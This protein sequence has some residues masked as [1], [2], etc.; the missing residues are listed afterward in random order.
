MKIITDS[1][2]TKGDWRI[3]SDQG[4]ELK[5][6]LTPGTNVSAQTLQVV[7]NTI[8]D[9]CSLICREF[10]AEAVTNI[11][12]YTAGVVT[13]TI[14]EGIDKVLR[15]AFPKADIEIQND[16][17]GCARA[18][19]GRRPGVAAILGT[20]SNSCQWDGK[21]IVSHV[22]SGGYILGDEG[23]ASVLGK[24]FLADLI[25]GRVPAEIVQEFADEGHPTGYGD[26]VQAVYH[27]DGA[28][29][30]FLGSLAPFIARHYFHP[31][32]KELVNGNFRDF[33][34]GTLLQYG[35]ASER[36][37]VVGGFGD[38]FKHVFT[39]L[40]QSYGIEVS[41]YFP[42]PVSGL[43]KYHLEEN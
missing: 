26:I 43:L 8:S 10:Q 1:G 12:F 25:K 13:D 5:R 24:R 2:A 36:V 33:I 4:S 20:G 22:N 27:S 18:A 31:Y 35:K 28:P 14:R 21:S 6:L 38:A 9:A 23:S 16:L 32:I 3:I 40:A 11:H 34:E 41:E 29:S 15:G 37:G 42:D 39:P 19:C 7:L 17:V 30:A